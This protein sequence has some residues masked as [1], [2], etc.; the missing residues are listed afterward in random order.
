MNASNILQDLVD[1]KE[2]TGHITKKE[3]L[4]KIVEFSTAKVSESTR[5]SKV[6]ALQVLNLIIQN[7]IEI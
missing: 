4:E 2:F 1:R 5:A 3:N 6:S 7:F